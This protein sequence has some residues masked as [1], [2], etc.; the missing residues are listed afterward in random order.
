MAPHTYAFLAPKPEAALRLIPAQLTFRLRSRTSV[1]LP[2]VAVSIRVYDPAGVPPGGGGGGGGGGDIAEPPPQP[3]T[4][5]IPSSAAASAAREYAR[6]REPA[7]FALVSWTS[8]SSAA[9]T[10]RSKSCGG[11]RRG[12]F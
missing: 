8:K 4:K 1:V 5:I 12:A 11:R 9:K 10:K 2:D 7:K 3:L 6:R